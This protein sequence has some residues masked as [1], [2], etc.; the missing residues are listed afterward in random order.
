MVGIVIV[1]HSAKLAE[2][3]AELARG[4]AG[5]DVRIAATGGLDMPD[6]PLG[7]DADLVRQAIERA[8]S[9]D[10][11][12]VLM[13]L[14]SAVLSA[15]MALDMLPPERRERVR[16]IDAPLVE[17][18]VAAAV[19]AR[20]G[21]SL[22]RVLEEAR[23]AL[24]PKASHLGAEVAPATPRET[25]AEAPP[26]AS[27]QL[28]VRNRLGLHARPAARF[29]QIA[30]GHRA[31]LRVRNLTT[32][33][34][35][36]NA[37]S[38]NAVAT[39]GVRQGHEIEVT[40]SGPDADAAL[41]AIRALADENFGDVEG[42]ALGRQP[43]T[44]IPRPSTLPPPPSSLRPPTSDLQPPT[45]SLQGLPA[46]PGIALGPS[47][48]FRPAIPTVE[49]RA[50][51]DPQAEW[52]ALQAA[53]EKT[54]AQI[55]ATRQVV[56]GRTDPYA[57]EIFDAHL[58]FLEDEALLAPA[59][60]AMF[61]E[62]LNAAASW[63]RAVEKVAA[64][65]RALDD[66]YQ[67]VRAD[68]VNDVGR[69]VLL[70]LLGDAAPASPL[71]GSG[72]LIGPDLTP[73]DTARLDPALVLGIGLAFGGP[74]S[75]SAILARAY[76]IPAV[77]G[78]G[79]GILGLSE[80]TPLIVD[81]G[82]GQ[83]WANPDRDL[84]AE[85][86]RRAEAERAE[87]VRARAAAE[88]PAVTRDGRRIDVAANIGSPAD[89]RVAAA[90][91]A[92]SV[93]LFR[94]E[95]L[96]LDRR[97]APDED[98]QHAAYRAAAEAMGGRPV[99]IRTL[100]VG[101]DKPLPYLDLGAE[102]NPFLGWRAI[103]VSLAKPDLFKAQLRAVLR[104]A[105]E[106]P[107]KV[108]F[109]MIATPAEW[110]AAR[111]LLEVARGELESRGQTVPERIEAGIMVEIPAAALRADQFAGEV[112]FFSI[113]TND[114]TQ[115]TLAAERGNPRVAELADAFQPAV[116]ELIRRVVEAAHARGKW[117]GVCGEMAGD[118]AAVPLL[119]GL[120]VDELSMNPP[121]IPQAKQLI[122]GLDY[123]STRARALE[124]L[125]LETPEAVRSALTK[126]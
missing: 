84:A 10:G 115:Y 45:S 118:P 3:A 107:V 90:N 91:G 109:P 20:L 50:S 17:G 86:A 96:F 23:G 105:A 82:T 59:H 9:D 77:V 120:G 6:S 67:R 85:Y 103:R 37:K 34:G 98:E 113:G 104:A 72:I 54:R 22:D 48:L 99:I 69:H 112:D 1:S 36:A 55:R 31:E 100:D 125:A 65:Y 114:L 19:Q 43:P 44:A 121:A 70:N 71:T 95:F 68:D 11:V 108:M 81:G 79:D 56:F 26:G 53:I 60:E 49:P 16:L 52:Q 21:A 64:E 57:A 122:R 123:V 46:S 87:R 14:G 25:V 89:A 32:G 88:A 80:G 83:V 51:S 97:D 111:E 15:E 12:V 66:E 62:K 101:G 29:V 42:P 39:L 40:A 30:A 73:A 119:V 27:L 5:P 126:Q 7:T 92:E 4:M 93:G 94:T 2:G 8:H 13:D 24:E 38:I 33:S 78:L 58:L 61:G 116:L 117:V 102:A 41:A 47:L 74:T 63:Q 28:R 76:G 106:F 18:A 124:A 75:H 110:R 35:P